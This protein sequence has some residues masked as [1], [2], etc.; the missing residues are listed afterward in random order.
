MCGGKATCKAC[1]TLISVCEKC[2]GR[3][4]NAAVNNGNPLSIRPTYWSPAASYLNIAYT[5]N[6][7]YKYRFL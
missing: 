5:F 2:G 1:D 3:K 7:Q 6:D 4:A